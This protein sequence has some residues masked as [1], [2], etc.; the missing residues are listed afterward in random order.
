VRHFARILFTLCSAVSLVLC[1]AA[2][3]LWVRSGEG[4][5]FGKVAPYGAEVIS[6]DGRLRLIL[7][8][9]LPG[10]SPFRWRRGAVPLRRPATARSYSSRHYGPVEAGVGVGLYH[11]T[12]TWGAENA[13]GASRSDG[14]VSVTWHV[15]AAP[16]W[17]VTLLA[18]LPLLPSALGALARRRRA[19]RRARVGLCAA[20]GYDLRASP[21]RCPECGAAPGT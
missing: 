9:G 4:D 13:A 7:Y 2:A 20:C 11:V 1:V 16:H 14:W 18:A 17:L 19:A 10:S 12:E 8:R 21:A 5:V 15:L 3:A 6:K